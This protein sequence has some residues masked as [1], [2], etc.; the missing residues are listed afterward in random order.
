MQ[1]L[2]PP[3]KSLLVICALAM[4]ACASATPTSHSQSL[5]KAELANSQPALLQSITPE[6]RQQ[7][8]N[9]IAARLD[10]Q[11]IT[12]A[13]RVFTRNPS[14]VIARRPVRS[15]DIPN[16][17]GR[18]VDITAHHFDLFISGETCYISHRQTGLIDILSGVACIA[19]NT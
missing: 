19:T 13:T 6:I 18:I 8:T 7:I 12:I 4:M 10:K 17:E 15:F 3:H 1:N 2:S 5:K 16:G 9:L 14:I 11:D